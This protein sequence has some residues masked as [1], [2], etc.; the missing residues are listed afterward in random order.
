M[1]FLVNN[2]ALGRRRRS[3][4]KGERAVGGVRERGAEEVNGNES[5]SNC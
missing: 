5:S 3:K 1:P 4:R 2:R